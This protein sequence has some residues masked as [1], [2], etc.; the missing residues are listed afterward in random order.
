MELAPA[1]R[2]SKR[3][4]T[5]SVRHEG[6]RL[7]QREEAGEHGRQHRPSEHRDPARPQVPPAALELSCQSC[8]NAKRE[9]DGRPV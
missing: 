5:E 2:I 9:D 8:R 4:K 1:S 6:Q 3:D 7:R